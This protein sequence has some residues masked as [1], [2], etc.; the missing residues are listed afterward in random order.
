VESDLRD[1]RD[2]DVH[3]PENADTDRV[4]EVEIE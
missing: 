4:V 3:A 1:Q 2:P